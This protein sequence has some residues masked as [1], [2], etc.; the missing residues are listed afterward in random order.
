MNNNEH[1]IYKIEL[2]H[3]ILFTDAIGPFNKDLI[4]HYNKDLIH[5]VESVTCKVWG[6]IIVLHEMSLFTPEAEKEF[7]KTLTY[8]KEKG[9]RVVCLITKECNSS[10]IVKWQ[11]SQL[12]A[13][14]DISYSF[15][16]SYE[17]AKSFILSE[18]DN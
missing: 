4:T 1:G 14:F 8:R 6:Q 12:Y 16:D 9:L 7:R 2:D 15:V 17:V 18:L 5:A 13:E 11:F 10:E 3:N